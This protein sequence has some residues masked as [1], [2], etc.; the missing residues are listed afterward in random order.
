MEKLNYS[1]RN[2]YLEKKINEYFKNEDFPINFNGINKIVN[3][4]HQL[5]DLLLNDIHELRKDVLL[6]IDYLNSLKSLIELKSEDNGL[7]RDIIKAHIN[8]EDGDAQKLVDRAKNYDIRNRNINQFLAHIKKM[9]KLFE[10]AHWETK[11]T[12]R[13][14]FNNYKY[15]SHNY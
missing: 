14:S 4:Y 11:K 3:R 5:D 8:E 12:Y 2:H 7:Q 10:I 15:K 13:N 6:W 9:I 1:F